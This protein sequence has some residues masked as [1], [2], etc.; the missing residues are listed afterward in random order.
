MNEDTLVITHKFSRAEREIERLSSKI[1]IQNGAWFFKQHIYSIK[2][3]LESE[4]YNKIYAICEKIGDD[5]LHW[6]QSGKI[7]EAGLDIYRKEREKIRFQLL[8]LNKEIQER[9]P[10]IWE[11]LL[12]VFEAFVVI[13]MRVL[14]AFSKLIK[15]AAPHL[16]LESS[17]IFGFTTKDINQLQQP[18]DEDET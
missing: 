13:V 2:D 6:Y 4:H 3:L 1:H 14:P 15:M 12:S 9:V 8:S 11:N 16:N 18:K 5:I 10:T 17:K 7:S